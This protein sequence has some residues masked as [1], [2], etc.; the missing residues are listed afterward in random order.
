ME[1]PRLVRT[2]YAV[3]TGGFAYC[4]L[5]LG[6]L[7]WER[8]AS[9]EAWV[10]CAAQF[11]VYPHLLYLRARHSQRPRQ[12][13]FHNLF[14]DSTLFGAW[15]AYFGFEPVVTLGLVAATVLNAT[16]NRGIGG[17]CCRWDSAS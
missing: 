7:L 9:A 15:C 12:A 2:I 1:T 11:L 13:E 5:A 10:L 6:L 16:V 8:G 3:R 14:V 4:F 17:G